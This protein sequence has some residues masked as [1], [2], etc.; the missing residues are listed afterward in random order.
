MLFWLP[1]VGHDAS[2]RMSHPHRFQDIGWSL[3]I[4]HLIANLKFGVHYLLCAKDKHRFC[5]YSR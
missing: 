1:D 2:D 5:L 4:E 3:P